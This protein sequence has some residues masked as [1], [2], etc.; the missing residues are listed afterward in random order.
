MNKLLFA[1]DTRICRKRVRKYYEDI[2]SIHQ[3][4]ANFNQHLRQMQL[5]ILFFYFFYFLFLLLPGTKKSV[6][7]NKSRSSTDSKNKTIKYN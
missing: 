6:Q 4:Q 3:T 5:V 1:K 2:Q 7:Y